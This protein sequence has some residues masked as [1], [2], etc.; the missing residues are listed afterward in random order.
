MD[1]NIK[2]AL[3]ADL[4][5]NFYR[6][7]GK[8]DLD[9]ELA[10]LKASAERENTPAARTAYVLMRFK[11]TRIQCQYNLLK[12][13]I[14]SQR[15]NQQLGLQLRYK[16]HKSVQTIGSTLIMTASTVSDLN[17]AFCRNAYDYVFLYK[18]S[19]SDTFFPTRLLTL[20][21]N[22]LTLIMTAKELDPENK[23]ISKSIITGFEFQLN[24]YQQLNAQIKELVDCASDNARLIISTKVQNPH[25]AVQWIAYTLKFAYTHISRTLSGFKTGVGKCIINNLRAQLMTQG[26]DITKSKELKEIL[27]KN[28]YL[29]KSPKKKEV[30]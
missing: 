7:Q 19:P 25:E 27:N 30:C 5:Y 11:A 15:Q 28:L 22:L 21:D 8:V 4:M 2:V 26:S 13:Y 24:T 16:M 14:E 1:N 10:E 6:D 29:I 12:A 20:I 23:I 18:I 9:E 3:V 17:K